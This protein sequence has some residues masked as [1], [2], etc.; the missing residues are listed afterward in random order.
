MSSSAVHRCQSTEV[1]LGAACGHAPERATSHTSPCAPLPLPMS[2]ILKYRDGS[3]RGR[4][5]TTKGCKLTLVAL[6]DVLRKRVDVG[7]GRLRVRLR[8]LVEPASR[9]SSEAHGSRH[10]DILRVR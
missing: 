2:R 4:T 6:I 1:S 3:R 8:S 5:A 9:R 10:E 7:A